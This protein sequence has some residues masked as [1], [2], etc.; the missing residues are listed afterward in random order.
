M[1]PPYSRRDEQLI[2]KL[3]CNLYGERLHFISKMPD[4]SNGFLLLTITAASMGFFHTIVGPDHYI[5]FIAMAR[6]RK[7]SLIKTAWITLLCG[8][9]HILSSVAIGI[10]GVILGLTV[11][12]LEFIESFRGDIAGWA[13]IVFGLLYCIWGVRKAIRGKPH[14]HYHVHVHENGHIH[15]HIHEAEHVHVHGN[16]DTSNLTPWI[17]FTIFIFGPCEPLIPILMYPAAKGNIFGVIWVT[18]IFGFTTIF[19]MLGLVLVSSFGI[20]FF[21]LGHLER[22]SHALAGGTICLCGMAIQFLGL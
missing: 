14:E 12:K 17:L 8:A 16:V 13:L 19:T 6:A 9:G 22:Y 11:A 10:A 21:P 1:S 20:N 5:P 3:H 2:R 15:P 7:W 18:A 4:I